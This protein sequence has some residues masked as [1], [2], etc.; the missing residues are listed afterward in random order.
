MEQNV[1]TNKI[2]MKHSSFRSSKKGF[3]KFGKAVSVL[4][5][6]IFAS[7][8][9][10]NSALAAPTLSSSTV[11]PSTPLIYSTAQNISFFI[12]ANESTS[13]QFNISNL[14]FSL[15]RPGQ[16]NFVNFTA[17]TTPFVGNT[18]T[19]NYSI[20]FTQAL[21]GGVGTYNYYWIATNK[22]GAQ[23][24]TLPT[25]AYVVN[26]ATPSATLLVT[27]SNSTTY[28]TTTTAN[29][30][31]INMND[32]G[33]NVSLYRNGTIFSSSTSL[34]TTNEAILLG[35]GTYNYTFVFNGTQNFT[36]LTVQNITTVS[37]GTQTL[38]ISSNVTSTITYP[39][40]SNITGSGC[41]FGSG[42]GSGVTC[43]LYRGTIHTI[44]GN[45]A[46]DVVLL[47]VGT[48]DYNYSSSGDAN[49]TAASASNFTLTVDQ[50]IPT[51]SLSLSPSTPITYET[52]TNATCTG[53]NPETSVNLYRNEVD[54]NSENDTLL[55]LPA[56]TWTYVCNSSATE[57]YTFATTTDSYEVDQMDAN[58]Q[59]SP[60]TNTSTYPDST[61]LEYC[62]TDSAL[63]S[64]SLYKNNADITSE[65]GTSLRLAAGPYDY[66]ANISDS[67]NYT[68][69][70]NLS[71]VTVEKGNATSSLVFSPIPNPTGETLET[72][73]CSATSLYDEALAYLYNNGIQVNLTENGIPSV[74]PAGIYNFGCNN[75]ETENYTANTTTFPMTVTTARDNMPPLVEILDPWNGTFV[76]SKNPTISFNILDNG[77]INP[78][79]LILALDAGGGPV[80]L[81]F[82]PLRD[83]ATGNGCAAGAISDIGISSVND[84]PYP[85]SQVL[86]CDYRV[87]DNETLD[88]NTTYTLTVFVADYAGNVGE[89]LVGPPPLHTELLPAT[90]FTVDTTRALNVS[91]ISVKTNGIADGTFTNGW[92]FKFNISTGTGGNAVSF[93]MDDWQDSNGNHILVFNYTRM[94]YYDANG[95]RRIYWVNN[96]YD[97]NQALYPLQDVDPAINGTQGN[98]TVDV[99]I[100]VGTTAGSYSTSYGVGLYNIGGPV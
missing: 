59:L 86:M 45:N 27:P 62:T 69:Y 95:T 12:I 100:P 6:V 29:G 9:F 68:N 7:I 52:Q 75:A 28:P 60:S 25:V 81:A 54:A 80:P 47:G 66:V 90:T 55:Y 1:T 89:L 73:I 53:T 74:R 13:N 26:Q 82:S 77:R 37:K 67:E 87:R 24:T 71:S 94:V 20:N 92:S 36:S 41:S 10:V 96:T 18:T 40:A 50:G 21:F 85:I 70:E 58:V 2:A 19:G 51:T 98:I 49:W 42:V 78:N 88:D 17:S 14:T 44:T 84:A 8:F 5:A 22:T 11:S 43:T 99:S 4:F 16:V 91:L 83:P 56:G 97:E 61:V 33:W 48:Y 23:T 30:T 35:V 34:L 63:L 93:R 32:T 64:C 57:N 39:K 38:T 3:L 72:V 46:Q 79:S 31:I 76:G 65:N 15:Q